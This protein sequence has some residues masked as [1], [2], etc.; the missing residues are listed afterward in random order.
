[1]HSPSL[2]LLRKE[3]RELAV[4]RAW[5][6][7]LLVMG[8]LTGVCYISAARTYA[9]LSGWNGPA[10]GAGEIL[11]PLTGVWAP[12]FAACEL[13]AVF[14]LPFVA[15]RVFG[16]DRQTGALKLE[17]QQG[18]TAWVRVM[19]KASVLGFGWC[20]AML[21]ALSAIPLWMSYGGH[22]YAPETASL[23][24]G[25]LLNAGLTMAFAGAAAAVT[26]HPSTAAVLTLT[27]TVGTWILSFLAAVQGGFWER[28]AGYTPNAMLG[29]FQHGLVRSATVVAAVV[30]ILTGFGL[31]SIWLRLGVPFTRQAVE[32]AVLM[33]VAAWLIAGGAVSRVS[34]DYS[35]NRANSFSRPDEAAL[36]GVR[37][38]LRIE[39]H[40]APEDP[41]RA[42]L[43]RSFGKL[44][45]TM[46][47]VRVDYV[48]AT[49]TGIFEQS[50]AGYGEI[51]YGLGGRTAT[52]RATTPEA[53]LETIYGLAGIEVPAGS[54]DPPYRGYPLA[55]P[56][57]GAGML[58]Y[59]IWPAAVCAAAFIVRRK[60]S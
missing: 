27:A 17:S 9:E 28:L 54:G 33:A 15:I 29:E 52:S 11:S 30:L 2:W 3:L 1:M 51:R 42:D 5:W 46:R 58:F 57:R 40:L 22:V 44:R 37:A 26:S 16:G 23:F 59:G 56:P 55:A 38:T 43:E 35:E 48:S 18:T 20:L 32:S 25:H 34:R 8:P 10:I 4:S 21:P 31:A 19:I 60:L 7:L 49:T 41:R 39:V 24:I 53:V 14:L 47:D 12:A 6:L 13:A 45:R 50:G 36:A